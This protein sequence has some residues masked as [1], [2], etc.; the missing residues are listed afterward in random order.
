[1]LPAIV[2][3]SSLVGAAIGIFMILTAKL[4]WKKPLPFGPYLAGAGALALFYGPQ[5]NAW[6]L[7]K[8]H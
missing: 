7:G 1:M 6:Y 2:L 4:G 8:F 3:L 5:I